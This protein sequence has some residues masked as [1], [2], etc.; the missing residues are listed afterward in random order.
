MSDS[1]GDT[2][3]DDKDQ[4][5]GT[6]AGTP[7]DGNGCPLPPLSR[8]VGGQWE[9][10][11]RL[12]YNDCSFGQQLG[13]V[14]T[15]YYW[16]QEQGSEDGY[17]SQGE[18]FELWQWDGDGQQWKSAGTYSMNLPVLQLNLQM[19]NQFGTGTY[20][21]VWEFSGENSGA[22]NEHDYYSSPAQ[23]YMF[24]GDA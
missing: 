12:D 24:W 19:D 15:V 13:T 10:S 9:M 11:Y 3:T 7:V 16:F 2:I 22:V 21:I 4:C 23:C 8:I 14:S 1:D 6:A 17:I 20:S 5:P 18:T